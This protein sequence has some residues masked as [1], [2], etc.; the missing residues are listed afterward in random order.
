[1][2]GLRD[3]V[4]HGYFAINYEIVWEVIQQNCRSSNQRS[5][6]CV[7][8]LNQNNKRS[9]Q[10]TLLSVGGRERGITHADELPTKNI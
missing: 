3:K 1:M 10:S 2:A 9:R 8:R 7:M 6:R 4:I 5:E